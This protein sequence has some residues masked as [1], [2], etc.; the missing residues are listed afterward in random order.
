M[1]GRET[2]VLKNNQGDKK[3]KSGCCGGKDK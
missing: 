1:G 3:K 2:L